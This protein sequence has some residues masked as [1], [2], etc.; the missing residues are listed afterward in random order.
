MGNRN[1]LNGARRERMLVNKLKEDGFDIS[2]RSAG[3]HSAI[4]VVAIRRNPLS[5]LFIQAKPRSLSKRK[6]TILE[7]QNAWLND[8]FPCRFKVASLYKE[9]A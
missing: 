5:I 3:S 1:Y 6:R 4:D 9:L 8:I 7:S 2:F